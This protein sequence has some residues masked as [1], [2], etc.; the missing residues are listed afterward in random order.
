MDV[1]LWDTLT[2]TK[3]R[4]LAADLAEMRARP[5]SLVEG[6][7]LSYTGTSARCSDKDLP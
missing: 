1:S 3:L 4:G 2:R 7:T 6:A 5:D